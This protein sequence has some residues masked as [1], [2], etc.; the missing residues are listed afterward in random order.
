MLVKFAHF[1][2]DR[3]TINVL[4]SDGRK[5]VR[6]G[7]CALLEK[8]ADIHVV[9]EAE[10]T[11]S[12]IKLI[13]P[14]DARAVILNPPASASMVGELLAAAPHVRVIV[15]TLGTKPNEA[16]DLMAAG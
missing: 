15:L 7:I 4:I 12:A 11:R 10:D 3:G 5:I 2:S 16:R 8:H 14:L 13:A 9:G 1:M 6:E